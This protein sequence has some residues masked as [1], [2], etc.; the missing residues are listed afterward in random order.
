[1]AFKIVYYTYNYMFAILYYES[2]FMI[3]K[4]MLYGLYVCDAHPF[5]HIRDAMWET[6]WCVIIIIIRLRSIIRFWFAWHNVFSYEIWAL[7]WRGL[8]RQQKEDV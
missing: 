8:F 1:M 3:N 7:K 5:S 2:F 6:I 4:N